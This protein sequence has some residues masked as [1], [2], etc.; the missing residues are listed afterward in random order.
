[1]KGSIV[2]LFGCAAFL[3]IAGTAQGRAACWE[4]VI[5][6]WS[7]DNRVTGDYTVSCYRRAIAKLPEDLR[8]YSSAPDDIRRGLQAQLARTATS[9]KPATQPSGSF[10]GHGRLLVLCVVLAAALLVAVVAIR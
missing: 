9:A 5:S 6:D 4:R 2:A 10:G 3:G 8:A 7:V 1:M